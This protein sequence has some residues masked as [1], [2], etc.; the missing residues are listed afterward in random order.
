MTFVY[1]RHSWMDQSMGYLAREHRPTSEVDV[2]IVPKAGHH[3]YAD[4]AEHFNE[5]LRKTAHR[6]RDG[7]SVEES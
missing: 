3:V 2:H 1:G 4:N 5:V 6:L 7:G